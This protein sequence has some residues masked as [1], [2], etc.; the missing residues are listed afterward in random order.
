[1]KKLLALLLAI[2]Q[3]AVL[4]M[5]FCRYGI[6]GLIRGESFYKGRPTSYWRGAVKEWAGSV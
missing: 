6:V 1:M 5:P 4:A 3:V 2:V